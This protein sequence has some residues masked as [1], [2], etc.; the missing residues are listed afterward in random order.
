MRNAIRTP[1]VP[2]PQSEPVPIQC[3]WTNH[4]K[5]TGTNAPARRVDD[6]THVW[7][8]VPV[9]ILQGYTVDVAYHVLPRQMSRLVI[10]DATNTEFPMVNA[11]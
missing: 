9:K 4:R 1:S 2:A 11:S 8:V 10:R 6:G 3:S 5:S 7:E